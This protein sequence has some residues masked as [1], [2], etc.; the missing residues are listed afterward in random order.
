MDTKPDLGS[1]HK[2]SFPFL[3]EREKWSQVSTDQTKSTDIHSRQKM[4][5]VGSNGNL[6]YTPFQLI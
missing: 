1:R 5:R 2:K 6:Y 3:C 4:W